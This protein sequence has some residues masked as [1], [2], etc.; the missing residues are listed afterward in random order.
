MAACPYPA[1]LQSLSSGMRRSGVHAGDSASAGRRKNRGAASFIE[2]H[3]SSFFMATAMTERILVRC[4][5][6]LGDVV[7]ATP[8]LRA[9][10]HANPDA[11][12]V[13]Q[14]PSGLIPLLEGSGFCDE[15]WPVAPRSAGIRVLSAEARRVAKFRFDRGVLIPESISSALRMRLGR[16]GK[17]AGYARDP[18]RRLLLDQV[19]QAPREWG[20]RRLISRERFVTG[21]MTA[22]GAPTEDLRLSLNVSK[23]EEARLD[24][25]LAVHDLDLEGLD[26]DRPVVFAPGASFG[27]SKCWPA[28]Y[29]AELADR[30]AARG[31]RVILLGGPGE[32]NLLEEVRREMKSKPI[33]LD[34]SLDLGGLKAL[35]RSTRLLVAND[36]G[37]RHIAAAFGIPSVVFLGPTSLEKTADN[38][39]LIEIVEKDHDCRPCYQR[40]CPIDH[41]CLRSISVEDADAAMSRALL[42]AEGSGSKAAEPGISQ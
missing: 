16:V 33:V 29:Y 37:T 36:A 41:R 17:I 8:G 11:R 2:D 31:Q 7:M 20:R 42:R 32:G 1:A 39:D 25:V 12:I 6:W 9:L 13:A 34:A 38:L 40:T 28:V 27:A 19:V 30:S 15:L 26:R 24:E 4:P 18:V 23:D 21:L 3:R 14:L 22:L 10:R 5:N 35:L